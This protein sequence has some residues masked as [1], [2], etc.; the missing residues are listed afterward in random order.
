MIQTIPLTG[1]YEPAVSAD[2][3]AL[4][5]VHE[6][7]PSDFDIY[8]ATRP[9]DTGP[10]DTITAFSD[11]APIYADHEPTLPADGLSMIFTSDRLGNYQAFEAVRASL[12]E[13]FGSATVV[14][15][16]LPTNAVIGGVVTTFDG[17]RLYYADAAGDIRMIERASRG[18]TFGT[19]GE[20]LMTNAYFPA[21]SPD[22]LELFFERKD[23]MNNSSVLRSTRTSTSAPFPAQ[24]DVIINGAG[25]PDVS[26][27]ST[28]LYLALA[29]SLTV[30]SRA[31]P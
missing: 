6:A 21:V 4:W 28:R 12:A 26:P 27:D 15:P 16:L 11:N 31:C 20:V 7:G 29:G 3:R 13:P 19:E 23:A 10:Y 22:E 17:L 30:M 14:A 18:E 24:A 9:A 2:P 1:P 8:L 5:F 25:D